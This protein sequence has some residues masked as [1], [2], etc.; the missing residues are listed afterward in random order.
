MT[1]TTILDHRRTDLRATTLGNPY[2]LTSGQITKLDDDL[3]A[4]LFSFPITKS[5]SPGYKPLFIEQIVFEVEIAF[6]GG[7]PTIDIASGTLAT[8]AV[9]TDGDVTEV[10]ATEY[11]LSD[12]I[13]EATIGYYPACGAG[14]DSAWMTAKLAGN[15]IH[16]YIIVP[17]DTTVPC[18]YA[19]LTSAS[20][21]TAGAGRLHILICEM[22]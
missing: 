21:I 7:T 2:W 9:T 19:A 10:V 16:P 13:T 5:V 18:I 22:P 8:D 12:N 15:A 20:P 14:T 3:A 4:L 11:M 17:A 1:T 6:L